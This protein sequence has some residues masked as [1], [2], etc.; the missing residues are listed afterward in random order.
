MKLH[1]IK[2]E[3]PKCNT[4]FESLDMKGMYKKKNDMQMLGNG[5]GN[6]QN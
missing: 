4:Y 5:L 6:Q 2:V 3:A 1:L